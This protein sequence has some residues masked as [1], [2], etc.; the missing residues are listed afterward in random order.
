MEA[1]E[2]VMDEEK[3]LTILLG[4][5]PAEY[6]LLV[7]ILEYSN[8]L[9]LMNV[10]EKLLKEHDEKQQKETSEGV[11]RVCHGQGSRRAM[12]QQRTTNEDT[13]KKKQFRGTC[14]R[15]DKG[16]HK[17]YECKTK[18]VTDANAIAF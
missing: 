6:E 2:D 3:T 5:L 13:K 16:G 18:N 8:G 17:Q 12:R 11:F 15:Y 7:T 9:T 1:F 4:S 14:H 10:K